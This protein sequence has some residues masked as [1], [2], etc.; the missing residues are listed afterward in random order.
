MFLKMPDDK[1]FDIKQN[2]INWLDYDESKKT[3]I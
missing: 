3:G 1:I 2:R